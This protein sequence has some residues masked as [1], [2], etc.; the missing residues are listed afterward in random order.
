M[1]MR[2]KRTLLLAG[3]VAAGVVAGGAA[4]AARTPDNDDPAELR[5][6]E[7][8]TRTH[9]DKA[10]VTQGEAEAIARRAHDGKVASIHLEDDGSGLEWEIE[11]DDG[12]SVWEVNVNA[13]TG[14][15]NDS[16]PDDQ[17][18]P[19]DDQEEPDDQ[20]GPSDDDDGPSDD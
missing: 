12:Q 8:F 1:R 6:Q 5:A 10:G 13:Q 11:I 9:Q 4:L 14:S 7:A 20:E 15:V 17:E 19:S 3:V 18:G 2:R 16:E